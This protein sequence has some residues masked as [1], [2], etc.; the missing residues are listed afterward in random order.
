MSVDVSIIGKK[1]C[2]IANKNSQGYDDIPGNYST[3]L[4]R[5]RLLISRTW[6]MNDSEPQPSHTTWKMLSLVLFIK[7][8]IT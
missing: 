8:M 4:I 1:L 6:S 3:W 7:S 2:N 5:P